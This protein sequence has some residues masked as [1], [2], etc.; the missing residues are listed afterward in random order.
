MF[1]LTLVLSFVSDFVISFTLQAVYCYSVVQAFVEH[2]QSVFLPAFLA[3]LEH[4]YMFWRKN[5]GV[6][7]AFEQMVVSGGIFC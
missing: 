2:C 7:L 1:I 5:P 3:F 6:V 4:E